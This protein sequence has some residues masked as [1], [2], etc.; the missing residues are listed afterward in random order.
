MNR[1]VSRRATLAA[2]A[3]GAAAS[4]CGDG[5]GRPIRGTAGGIVGGAGG[6]GGSSIADAGDV[7]DNLY[8][9]QAMNWAPDLVALED[10]LFES[11][12]KLRGGTGNGCDKYTFG[13]APPLTLAPALRCSA[14]LHAADM[15][16][17]GF[18]SQTNPD[19]VGPSQRMAVAGFPSSNAA[20]DIGQ[21]PVA[22]IAPDLIMPG[23]IQPGEPQACALGDPTLR[24]AGV[25]HYGVFWVIDVANP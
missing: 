14:R 4:A 10:Q 15:A 25:G 19:M 16:A 24:Y 20:E 3:I 1:W 23:M 21:D 9:R 12:N 11:I 22:H 8:C 5:I 6:G 7:P 2:L 18:Y 17:R 13:N